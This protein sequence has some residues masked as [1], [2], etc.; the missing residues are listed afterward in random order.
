LNFDSS[1]EAAAQPRSGGDC[2]TSIPAVAKTL[3][4]VADLVGV[5]DKDFSS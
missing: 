2:V 3:E 1:P 4:D 5:I